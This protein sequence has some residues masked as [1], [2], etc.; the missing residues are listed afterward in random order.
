ME[1]FSLS[2]DEIEIYTSK[3]SQKYTNLQFILGKYLGKFVR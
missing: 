1:I 3:F 2:L